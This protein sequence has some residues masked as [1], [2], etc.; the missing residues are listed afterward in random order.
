MMPHLT[1]MLTDKHLHLTTI[2]DTCV[3][4]DPQKVVAFPTIAL[5][6][7]IVVKPR[8]KRNMSLSELC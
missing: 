2:V 1:R 5:V 4:C 8:S 3:Q 7:G 6:L